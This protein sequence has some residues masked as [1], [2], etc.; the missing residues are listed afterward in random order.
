ME[1][2]VLKD[3]VVVIW[4]FLGIGAIVVFITLLIIIYRKITPILDAA[5]ETADN[6]RNTSSVVSKNVIQ[7][8]AKIQA[9]I[10]GVRKAA[11]VM[12]SMRKRGGKEN[13][14]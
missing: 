13:G 9:F 11:E 6:V 8:I 5:K 3:W 2:A 7:P 1:I 10:A 4:G 12:D 14:K